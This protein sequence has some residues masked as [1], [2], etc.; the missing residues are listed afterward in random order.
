MNRIAVFGASANTLAAQSLMENSNY[1]I[2]CA[3][4]YY[5]ILLTPDQ[6]YYAAIDSSANMY[7]FYF[8]DLRQ[9]SKFP[10]NIPML[11][12]RA[13]KDQFQIVK[14]TTDYFVAQAIKS[15]AQL[16][17]INYSDGQHDF[18]ILDDTEISKLIIRQ[19]VDFMK[20]YLLHK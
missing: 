16:T 12:T 7:G 15:N 4:L 13:G 8:S 3:I 5:G 17:F 20:T 9:I 14:N 2:K 6:K 18:D 1:N 19:T 10:E 11:V